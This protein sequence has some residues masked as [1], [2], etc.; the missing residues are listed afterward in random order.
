M[1]VARAAHIARRPVFG[2][3]RFLQGSAGLA[4][5]G[6]LAAP[7]FPRPALAAASR[8]LFTHGVQSGDVALTPAGSGEAVLW[9]RADR[10]A[11]LLVEWSTTESFQDATLVAGPAALQETDFT[12]KL[13]LAGL[14][15]GQRIFYRAHFQDL[16][17]AN[18]LSEDFLGSFATAPM[19]R[20][21][22][23]LVWSGDT[24]GQGWGINEEWGGM[25]IYETM[26]RQQPDL[27]LHSGDTIYA[28]GPILP[29]V[30][31]PDG[32]VWKNLFVPEKAKVAET[33]AEY[34]AAYKYNLLDRNLV[35]FNA[36]VPMI[37]QWD[38][39]ETTNNWY[40]QELLEADERYSVKS[41]ALLS[42]RAKRAFLEFMP[43]AERDSGREQ[44][45]RKIAYGPL[46]DIF[47]IDMRSFRGPNSANLQESASAETAFLGRPQLAWLEAGLKASTAT[48]KIVASDMPLG[49]QVPD[50]KAAWEAVANGDNGPARGRELEIAALLTAIKEVKNVVWL[51]ADVHYTAAHYYDPAQARYQDFSPFWEFVSGPL[52]AG[53]FGPGKLDETFGPQLKVVKAPPEGQANLPPSAGL[54]FFGQVEIA[55]AS[56]RM[57]VTLKDLENTDLY[58]VELTP[59]A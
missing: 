41:V 25:R 34:R 57:T 9:A 2:R 37:A 39:H 5:A 12:A 10:N 3:R 36:E 52:N 11:R 47:V 7:L 24:A 15:A 21:D 53:T 46:L 18:G 22:L 30:A 1:T 32:T 20:R 55:G 29:A 6:L 8:P 43:L 33:L 58:T 27:F 13:M 44:I 40:P 42:A 35:A 48:W 54:Q 31:L 28:D 59:E 14:P 50:G 56:G 4:G 17:D 49:L 19:E 26:R 23:K 16:S 45:Y 51:T 38:D